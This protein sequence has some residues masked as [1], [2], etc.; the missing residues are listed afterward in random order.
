MPFHW[1]TFSPQSFVVP[2]L[3]HPSIP[4]HLNRNTYTGDFR[5]SHFFGLWIRVWTTRLAC[6]FLKTCLFILCIW[7]HCSCTR[8]LWAV[9]W[10]LGF[11]LRTFRR[12]ISALNRWSIS[13][14]LACIF[15]FIFLCI[16]EDL[17]VNKKL[18]RQADF[19]VRGQPGL[20]RETLSP[21]QN[22]QIK[23]FTWKC[24]S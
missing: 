17:R 23:L 1:D 20:H 9:M 11:E 18:L 24:S 8:W 14:A 5:S 13:P 7:V 19:W 12:S 15:Y 3:L 16:N 4:S 22:K 2:G 10:L 21:K 6:I